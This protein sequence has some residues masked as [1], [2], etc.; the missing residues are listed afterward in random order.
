MDASRIAIGGILTECNHLSGIPIDLGSFERYELLRGD[1]LLNND[2]GVVG[3][4][5]STL[6][7]CDAGIAPLLFASTCPGGFVT[8]DCYAHLKD[9]LL[10]RLESAG[11]IA[12]ILLPLHG[13]MTVDG[14]CDPEGDLITATRELVGP[15][16]PIIA[17]LDLH[18]Q[19]T[20]AMVQQANALVAWETYPHRDAYS[21]GARAAKLMTL[22]ATGQV[23]PTMAMARVPV[24]TSAIHGSTDDDGPFAQLMRMAKSMEHKSEVLSCSVFLG[25]PYI[26]LP[27]MGSGGLV[28]TDGN[29][30]LA[31]EL[32]RELA[33]EYWTRRA[34]LEPLVVSPRDAILAA[35]EIPGRPV[36][37]I[38]AADCCGGGAA[39]DSVAVLRALLAHA[40]DS[41]A[42]VPVVD[43]EAAAE[44]HA[45]GVGK[46]LALKL[47]HKH[48][49]QWGEPILF[50]GRVTRLGDG[51]FHYR[52]GIWE[53]VEGNMGPCAVL[54]HGN[55][56]V[57]VTSYATYDWADEQYRA[58]QL[59]PETVDFIVVKNPMNYRNAYGDLAAAKYFLDTSGPTP[60]TLRHAP[61][62]RL[63]HA[64]FPAHPDRC[65]G[66]PIMM[67]GWQPGRES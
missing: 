26:D 43:T 52:G 2:A 54:T 45:G 14:I 5:V 27:A 12:G 15:D 53:A 50:E 10:N 30:P 67:R 18:A 65:F 4:M 7:Q 35:A 55:I 29:Q 57:L 13:A 9:D 3:G 17:T 6:R 63:A 32:A 31:E 46:T 62:Q 51:T 47:G 56:H 19:V 36:L 41:S 61:F 25:H 42:I 64:F 11:Q 39:G 21:T 40:A 16:V 44:C 34:E 8:G 59:Q 37:L 20:A 49:P 60:A 22:A 28:I 38:E 33:S 24:I 58:M 48:D 23:R 1:E 66:E